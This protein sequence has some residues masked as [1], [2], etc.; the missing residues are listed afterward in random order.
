MGIRRGVVQMATGAWYDPAEPGVPGSLCKHGNPN[1]LT[2]DRGTSA[3]AQ[4][5]SAQTTLVEVT[6]CDD[7]PPVTAFELPPIR[8]PAD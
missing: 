7:P 2:L 4:A 5:C 3:L 1:L 8:P 6:R